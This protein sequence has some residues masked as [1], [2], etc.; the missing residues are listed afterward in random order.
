MRYDEVHLFI[1]VPESVWRCYTGSGP[2]FLQSCFVF[3][4]RGLEVCMDANVSEGLLHQF[5]D[6]IK[7]R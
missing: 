6:Y 4:W 1:F 3:L 7:R 2:V 5:N